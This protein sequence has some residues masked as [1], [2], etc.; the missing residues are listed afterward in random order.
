MESLTDLNA[1]LELSQSR[2]STLSTN[3]SRLMR[4]VLDEE[5]E[6]IDREIAQVKS[7]SYERLRMKYKEAL[8]ECEAKQERARHRLVAAE[9][10][11]DIRFGAMIE[12]EWSQ[13]HV[14]TTRFCANVE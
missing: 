7:G 1:S 14:A 10:E 13:F 9:H 6:I 8:K 11:I 5:L 3:Y 12:T 2:I 4:L